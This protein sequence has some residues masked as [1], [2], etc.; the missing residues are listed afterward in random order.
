MSLARTKRRGGSRSQVTFWG[1]EFH[2]EN[3]SI[4]GFCQKVLKIHLFDLFV[5]H[6]P[7]F[8]TMFK[9]LV[10]IMLFAVCATHFEARMIDALTNGTVQLKYTSDGIGLDNF[11]S[12]PLH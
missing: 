11:G 6:I 12:V 2:A 7:D 10:Y 5:L 1:C 4:R 9:R 8:Y 3:G